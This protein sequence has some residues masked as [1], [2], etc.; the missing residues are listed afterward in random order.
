[1]VPLSTFSCGH[2]VYVSAQSFKQLLYAKLP[3]KRSFEKYKP[4]GL[5]SEFYGMSR[6]EIN[7]WVRKEIKQMSRGESLSENQNIS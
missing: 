4:Q 7:S 1:M 3:W 6:A 5:F 2:I